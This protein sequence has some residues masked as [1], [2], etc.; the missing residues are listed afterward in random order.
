M[1]L[2]IYRL[3]R[4]SPAPPLY[5]L[6]F[7][8]QQSSSGT[9]AI[10]LPPAVYLASPSQPLAV[11]VQRSTSSCTVSLQPAAQHQLLL[12]LTLQLSVSSD[13]VAA[14]TLFLFRKQYI[15]HRLRSFSPSLSSYPAAVLGLFPCSQQSIQ[16]QHHV[17]VQRSSGTT[18]IVSLLEAALQQPMVFTGNSQVWRCEKSM[19]GNQFLRALR[20]TPRE[21]EKSYVLCMNV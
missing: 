21:S 20:F 19:A 18:S 2:L 7:L 8:V 6:T 12:S 17:R 1:F 13:A 5:P 16:D 9:D 4:N 11:L 15:Q 10:S 14:L 3:T